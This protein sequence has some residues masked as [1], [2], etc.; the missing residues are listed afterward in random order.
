MP[1]FEQGQRDAIVA[2]LIVSILNQP[3]RDY[4]RSTPVIL[5]VPNQATIEPDHGFW[6]ENW[7]SV[8]GK[9]RI[10][11]STDPPPDL[12]QRPSTANS[13]GLAASFG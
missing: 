4:T 9:K 3:L 5:H 8:S 11:L 10:D 12:A 13:L 7:Q 1:T 2:D 6:I